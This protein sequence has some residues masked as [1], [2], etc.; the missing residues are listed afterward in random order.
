MGM[1]FNHGY[2]DI[3][4]II[5]PLSS[6]TPLLASTE[7]KQKEDVGLSKA[8]WS[9]IESNSKIKTRVGLI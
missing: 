6:L 7:R 8:I 5:T 4:M 1:S 2:V 3:S 9:Q